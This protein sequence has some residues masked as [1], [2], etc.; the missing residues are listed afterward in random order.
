MAVVERRD[1]QGPIFFVANKWNGRQKSEK[2][3]R[4]RREAERRDAAMKKEIE[5]GTYQPPTQ[6]KE[7]QFGDL[8]IVWH[9]KR[10][11]K[12]A[13]GEYAYTRNHL[14]P[15][16]WLWKMPLSKL[17]PTDCDKLIDELRAET[18]KDGTRKLSDKTIAD[19]LGLMK[20]MFAYAVRHELCLRNPVELEPGTWK[21]VPVVRETYT[22]AEAAVLVRNNRIPWPT[23]VL[24]ALWIL[25]GLRQGEGCGLKWKRLDPAALPL[26]SLEIAEQ[27][28]GERTK[29]K[30]TR[31]VPVHAE[32][33]AILTA[34]AETGFELHTGRKPTPEDYIVPEVLK[35]GTLRCYG[36]HTSYHRFIEACELVK[37]R[38]RTL[39]SCRHTFVTLCRRGGARA[40]VLERVSHNAK[41]AMIDRYTH[42]DWAPL[43]EAVSCLRLDGLV[44]PPNAP[45]LLGTGGPQE[46]PELALGT[47]SAGYSP[48]G[49][50]DRTVVCR[51]DDPKSTGKNRT[52]RRHGQAFGQVVSA[53]SPRDNNGVRW[54]ATLRL[55][56]RARREKLNALAE[57]DPAGARPGL[58]ICRA[59][60]ATLAGNGVATIAALKEAAE[61]L[62]L[63]GGGRV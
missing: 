4:N 44:S 35:D 16:A 30:K 15:R 19:V 8:A 12:S 32:L 42:F 22:A 62:G 39:H 28:E 26:A 40:D 25:A 49:G 46:A 60:E 58:A 55:A 13:A 21:H 59:Y 45:P 56:L 6:R 18:K 48:G 1:K 63:A 43:C 27:W 61:A 24:I 34:W 5:R 9:G 37:I 47:E 17:K 7:M 52:K 41:G 50:S 51:P 33:R 3:G 20:R 10:T 53:G 11:N 29:T 2:V 31:M 23:R 36:P 54:D 14:K 38:P 57:A